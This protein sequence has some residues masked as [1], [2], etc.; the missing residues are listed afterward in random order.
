M[1]PAPRTKPIALAFLAGLA[2]GALQP[3]EAAAQSAIKVTVNG[4]AITTNEINQ[5][6]RFLRLVSKDAAGPAVTRM[7]TE[8]LI[9][10]KL[11]LA[12]AKRL[13]ITA[14]DQQV[15]NAFASIASRMY[16]APLYTGMPTLTRGDFVD[17]LVCID[18]NQIDT[19]RAEI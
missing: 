12:E 6:A 11:K 2:A 5:R 10:E 7:A 8:E 16:F 4:E 19:I 9:E 15:D 14:T 17:R 3:L 1:H 18:E 13:K